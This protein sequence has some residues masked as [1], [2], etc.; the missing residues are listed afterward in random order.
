[1]MSWSKDFAKDIRFVAA[2]KVHYTRR[3]INNW[4]TANGADN[5]ITS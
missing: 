2:F 3:T 4:G 1:M 5:N